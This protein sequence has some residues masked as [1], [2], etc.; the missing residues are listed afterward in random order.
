MLGS[1][2]AFQLFVRAPEV[3]KQKI[4]A[5]LEPWPEVVAVG[6]TERLVRHIRLH[7][8]PSDS[9]VYARLTA[10]IYLS[11][12]EFLGKIYVSNISNI[13]Q[14]ED[15]TYELLEVCCDQLICLKDQYGIRGIYQNPSHIPRTTQEVTPQYI[16]V[17]IKTIST[18]SELV[19][20]SNVSSN[21]TWTT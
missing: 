16:T 3:V 13:P 9:V 2:P 17:D 7:S 14:A 11:T 1:V 18:D 10:P 12:V 5:F 8:A 19:G 21:I 6:Q 15:Q 20:L 4:A